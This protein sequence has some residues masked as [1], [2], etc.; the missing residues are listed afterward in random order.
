MA[1]REKINSAIIFSASASRIEGESPILSS[2]LQTETF[3]SLVDRLRVLGYKR[4]TL[5]FR[6]QINGENFKESAEVDRY[7]E[8]M[9][10]GLIIVI[11]GRLGH[12]KDWEC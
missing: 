5:K 4:T 12:A 2:K 1:T 10:T 3:R 9:K 6:L 7:T 11:F 8:Q